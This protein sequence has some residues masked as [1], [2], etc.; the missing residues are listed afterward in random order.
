MPAG[1]LGAHIAQALRAHQ[2]DTVF[3]VP[4]VHNIE[5]YR[6]IQAAG[7]TH[8]LARHEQGAGFMADGYA[9]ATSKPGVAFVITGPGLTNILTPMAQAYSDSV[10]LLVISSCLPLAEKMPGCLHQMRDQLGAGAAASDWSIL[11][12]DA[13]SA[14]ALL[15]RAFTEFANSRARPKHI[16]IPI[17]VLAGRCRRGAKPIRA[18]RHHR[19]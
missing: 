13:K 14:Y 5:L 7:I 19:P 15:D 12:P 18:H 11:A 8:V 2:V 4:G 6:G 17:D 10:A 9:R 16:T 3:G 1:T